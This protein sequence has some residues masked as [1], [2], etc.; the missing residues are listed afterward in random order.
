MLLRS[1]DP[2]E[3][4]ALLL[5]EPVCLSHELQELLANLQVSNTG[6]CSCAQ[7]IQHAAVLPFV[8]W[9]AATVYST[10]GVWWEYPPMQASAGVQCLLWPRCGRK[11]TVEHLGEGLSA[12]PWPSAYWTD[13]AASQAGK[14]CRLMH[15]AGVDYVPGVIV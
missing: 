14:L 7:T 9:R 5:P 4:G 3:D 13:S 2:A 12:L 1:P 11:D 15:V 6:C 8:W 10:S